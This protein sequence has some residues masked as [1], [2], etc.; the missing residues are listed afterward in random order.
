M[1]R[2]CIRMVCAMVLLTCATPAHAQENVIWQNPINV[3]PT[4]NS[5]LKD[6]GCS[7]CEDAG[8]V[9]TQTI[10]SGSGYVEFTA[11]ETNTDRQSGLAIPTR[12]PSPAKIQFPI[13]L[14]PAGI[15]EVRE[16]NVYRTDVSYAANDRLRIAVV[17]TTIVYS[18]N[19]TAFFTNTNP[20]ITYPLLADTALLTL[21]ATITNAVISRAASSGAGNITWAS[22][23]RVTPSGASLLKTSGCTGCEDAGAASSQTIAGG[24]GYIEFTATETNTDRQIGLSNGNPGTTHA[25]IDFSIR[26]TSGGTAEV[27][28]SDAYRGETS[29][30]AGSRF[31]IAVVGTT[32]VYS[33]NGTPFYTN[34]SPAITYPL[35]ADTSLL[36]L[37]ATIT[38]GF[39][40]SGSGGQPA[41]TARTDPDR[42]PPSLPTAISGVP[43]NPA[44]NVPFEDTYFPG[45]RV[46]RVTDGT[47]RG[48]SP[49]NVSYRTPS[50][51]WQTAWS[52][53]SARFYVIT[54]EGTVHVHRLNNG[55]PSY[56]RQLAWAIEPAFSRVTPTLIY[57]AR[58]AHVIEQYDFVTSS[59]TTI[60]NLDTD[61]DPNLA[62]GGVKRR[63]LTSAGPVERLLT[64]WGAVNNQ[65]EHTHVMV[66]DKANPANRRVIDTVNS[67][68]NGQPT[69]I[70]L[71][72][73]TH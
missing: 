71:G 52:S 69:N 29:Y 67:K 43:A 7:G 53:D 1:L 44:V 60:V 63:E 65:D 55:T 10:T 21:N 50:A 54:T 46:L 31:R 32:I 6:G 12:A 42:T 30:A 20:A 62:I 14:T 9:S 72:F 13:R 25:E 22:P 24:D 26:L 59:Y 64:R 28:E 61:P 48:T 34:T 38:D 23:I 73:T 4:G 57:G 5:L 36:T 41:Y 15:A 45:S 16:S 3:H 8:A 11:T 49:T 66:F 68:I 56:D 33:K 39:I 58:S 37:N 19:G 27:R 51:T 35:L 47:A 40:S 2:R 17:G 18:K 70:P